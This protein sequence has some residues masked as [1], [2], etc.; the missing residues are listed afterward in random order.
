MSVHGG[1][2]HSKKSNLKTKPN[3]TVPP[4]AC[5]AH[6]HVFGPPDKFP[7]VPELRY[8]PPVAP[9]DDYLELSRQLGLQRM[10]FVQPSA[11]GKDNS[12]M[13][14]AITMGSKCEG[15]DIGENITDKELKKCVYVRGISQCFARQGIRS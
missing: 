9:L 12:C 15:V 11:Y 5:D 6:F 4:L 13:F 3:F 14:D 1:S 10:V 8:T 2:P 7:Y